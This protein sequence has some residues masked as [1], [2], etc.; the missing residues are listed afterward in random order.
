MSALDTLD[1][2]APPV[3]HLT[4]VPGDGAPPATPR[5]AADVADSAPTVPEPVAPLKPVDPSHVTDDELLGRV[6]SGDATA[7]TELYDRVVTVVFG[8]VR[9]VVRDPAISEEVTHDVM[10][11]VW[12][13]ADRFDA[14]RGR[15]RSWVLTM[16]HRRAIDRVRSE[17]A[18]R[19]RINRVGAWE[20]SR[21][22]DDVAE[23][24]EA[25]F[26]HQQ[27]R[28]ALAGLTPVQREAIELTYYQGHTYREAAEILGAPLGTVKT[29]IRD[30][31][32]QL[33]H[34]LRATA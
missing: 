3:P 1:A 5:I 20:T 4:P 21:P 26:E 18:G 34:E 27:I 7:Y 30:G 33:R 6:G 28:D 2:L 13:N 31:L 25:R 24:V 11:E 14:T 12:R 23:A 16:A 32:R 10:L 8:V 29:R 9:R 19:D 22:F 17:Q 15:A